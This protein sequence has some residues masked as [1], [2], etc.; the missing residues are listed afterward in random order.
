M[1]FERL[2]G[3]FDSFERRLRG[4]KARKRRSPLEP[5]YRPLLAKERENHGVVDDGRRPGLWERWFGRP[6]SPKPA[7]QKKKRTSSAP[8]RVSHLYSGEP[9]EL[10]L[11]LGPETDVDERSVA[12]FL[13]SLGGLSHHAAFELVATPESVI[14]RFAC[15]AKDR[16]LVR[17][18]LR[19]RFPDIRIKERRHA[20]ADA[21]DKQT[22]NVCVLGLGL[23]GRVYHQLRSDAKLA[24][25]P[26]AGVFGVMDDLAPGECAVLQVLFAPVRSSWA[27]DFDELVSG[28][29]GTVRRRD[30][31]NDARILPYIREKFA[32][33]TFG[34][35]IRVAAMAQTEAGAEDRAFHIANALDAAT[36]SED[37]RLALAPASGL[38]YGLHRADLLDRQTRRHGMF[39]SLS[40]LA[41]IVHPPALSVRSPKLIRGAART[42]AAPLSVLSKGLLLGVNEHED[43]TREVRIPPDIRAR[44]TWMLGSTGSGKSTLLLNMAVQDIEAG[45]GFALI[46]PAGDLVD[47]ILE[48][49]PAERAQDVVLVDPADKEYPIGFNIL[50][51]HSEL[52]RTLL[53][54]D[55]VSVFRRLSSTTFGDQMVAILENAVLAFLEAPNGGTLLDLRRFLVDK[56]FRAEFLKGVED[57]EVRSFWTHEAGMISGNPYAS[58]LL[59]LNTFLRQ[60]S[61]RYMVSQRENKLD[62]RSIMDEKRILLVKLSHGLIGEENA[63]L[64]GSLLVSELARAALSRQDVSDRPPFSIAIDDFHHFITPSVASVL[65]S[66]RKYGVSLCLASHELRQ[67]KARSEEVASALFAHAA[68]RIVFHLGDQDAKAMADGFSYFEAPDIQNLGVGE[69]IVRV[70]RANADFNL[71]T[72][73]PK[74]VASAV[75]KGRCAAARQASRK[76]YATPRQT[77]EVNLVTSRSATRHPQGDTPTSKPEAR[78]DR[79]PGR[80]GPEHK[81]LQSLVGQLAVDRGF[82]V[83]LEQRV[84]DAHGYIDVA[85][86]RDGL[87]IGC[88]ISISTRIAHELGNLTKCLAAGF[89]HAVLVGTSR[90]VLERARAEMRSNDERVRFLLPDELIAFLD[91]LSPHI[92][93]PKASRSKGDPTEKPNEVASGLLDTWA[94]A[95]RVGL[96]RQTLAELRLNG[97]GPR[98][99]KLGRRVL[100]DP[101]ELDAWIA[102]RRRRSTSDAGGRR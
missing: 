75:A 54:S 53:A 96:A 4:M 91:S 88:E 98:F 90:R 80:G 8:G 81:Y 65:Q 10:E 3:R 37:N 49:I 51:P 86:E 23:S 13:G 7:K 95:R 59:R 29:E 102:S 20:L 47:A 25:D 32:E 45:R 50:A 5:R 100:Y 79:S 94:A 46:D 60:K 28:V 39:L 34:V 93:A 101:V 30:V 62:M 26:L 19:S 99:I 52:E 97:E 38:P 89:D 12:A 83:A 9:I 42:K 66:T 69:A 64:L 57:S 76:T 2:K 58:I 48:R 87:R 85:L 70:E 15:D 17:A 40:E 16:S 31:E 74:S 72:V 67:T 14:P 6:A 24:F 33:Q 63:H 82:N 41:T 68:T 77:V 44:H 35:V 78:R 22:G 56:E 92:S 61:V 21:W 71:R 18:A 84:L 11:V 27:R 36:R 43:E 55:F 1:D 73:L